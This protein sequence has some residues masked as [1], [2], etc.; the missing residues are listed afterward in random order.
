MV[1][2]GGLGLGLGSEVVGC[3]REVVGCTKE[4]LV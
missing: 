4:E 1:V 2:E 3:S